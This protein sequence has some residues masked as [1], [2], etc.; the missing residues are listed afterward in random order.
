MTLMK[1][2]DEERPGYRA[3]IGAELEARLAAGANG[4][5]PRRLRDAA[6]AAPETDAAVPVHPTSRRPARAR[7]RH[8]ERRR[9]GVLQALRP[10]SPAGGRR[11]TRARDTLAD[12]P[13]ARARSGRSA[14]LAH[15]GHRVR[16]CARCAGVGAA[17][18]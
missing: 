12:A 1:Q 11:V 10:P 4:R 16:G 3:I 5:R 9:R 13:A 14:R 18:S 8:G 15:R 2:L 17:G 6:V 7:L